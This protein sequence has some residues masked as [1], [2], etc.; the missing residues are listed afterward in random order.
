MWYFL[1]ID[2]GGIVFL[3]LFNFLNVDLSLFS[4]CYFL[5]F[6]HRKSDISVFPFS[7]LFILVLQYFVFHLKVPFHGES[8]GL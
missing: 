7:L 8:L 6:I 5:N 2:F 3:G 4:S 1:Y